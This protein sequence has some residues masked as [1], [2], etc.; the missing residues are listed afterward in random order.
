MFP[1]IIFCSPHLLAA[2]GGVCPAGLDARHPSQL[3]E[4]TL[5]GLVL[6]LI[7]RWATHS[8]RWLPRQ[9]AITGL[10]MVVYGVFRIGL[11]TVRNP[12]VGMPDFPFGLT[13]GMMLSTPMVLIGAWLIWRAM[14][15]EPAADPVQVA[16]QPPA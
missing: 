10:F 8:A 4:A 15:I 6:F 13:M 1:G 7:L 2:N 9:G 16:D 12:D 11:E 3:Y 14:R 5:E